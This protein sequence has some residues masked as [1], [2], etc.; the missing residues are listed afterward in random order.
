MY[1]INDMNTIWC[2]AYLA[3]ATVSFTMRSFS[4]TLCIW[5]IFTG[6]SRLSEVEARGDFMGSACWTSG[7]L[8]ICTHTYSLC[9][10]V[11][12][13]KLQVIH[14]TL[15]I[16]HS[17]IIHSYIIHHIMHDPSLFYQTRYVINKW[18]PKLYLHFISVGSINTLN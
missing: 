17:Y 13:H 4:F 12:H 8:P 3:A 11:L 16:V 2:E 7:L 14:H 10:H 5:A 18:W 15:Y 6:I 1:I 9:I